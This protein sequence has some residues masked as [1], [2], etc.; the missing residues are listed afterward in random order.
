M[1][2]S[3]KLALERRPC[4]NK[5]GPGELLDA[6]GSYAIDVLDG[7]LP[8]SNSLSHA[9]C[10]NSGKDFGTGA[11]LLCLELE[12]LQP[13]KVVTE[14]DDDDGGDGDDEKIAASNGVVIVRAAREDG[15]REAFSTSLADALGVRCPRVRVLD[16]S[17]DEYLELR[18]AV[19]RILERDGCQKANIVGCELELA[20]ESQVL[21]TE[22]AVHCVGIKDLKG[23]GGLTVD[24][25]Y[26]LGLAVSLDM[27]LANGD[28]MPLKG[29]WDRPGNAETFLF[30]S[31]ET[32]G[33]FTTVFAIDQ[34]CLHSDNVN[35]NEEMHRDYL[36]RLERVLSSEEALMDA[37]G[38]T[39]TFLEKQLDEPLPAGAA[40]LIAAGVKQGVRRASQLSRHRL[41][42]LLSLVKRMAKTERAVW[43]DSL[44]THVRLDFMCDILATF[45]SSAPN[46]VQFTRE[47]GPGGLARILQS[48]TT[49]NAEQ[50]THVEIFLD[51]DR[52]LTNG[53]ITKTD[54]PLAQRVRG[55]ALSVTAL[56]ST[57]KSGLHPYIVTARSP[58]GIVID[59]LVTS[60]RGPQKEI[61]RFFL[62]NDRLHGNTA[63]RC[64][65][66]SFYG[67]DL[68]F[69]TD[70]RLYASDYHKPAAIAHALSRNYAPC[71]TAD[72][73]L[74]FFVD[75]ASVNVHDVGSRLA[76][77]LVQGGR[78]D[79]A[80]RVTV[81]CYWWD[82]FREDTGMSPS[83]APE[84][85][86]TERGYQDFMVNQLLDFGISSL[87]ARRRRVVYGVREG[88]CGRGKGG[89]VGKLERASVG[90][91]ELAAFLFGGGKQKSAS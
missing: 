84:S 16:A 55:G 79:L 24:M 45:H 44:L 41:L 52:T 9:W 6:P 51:F 10:K 5:S 19:S 91:E 29:L 49:S 28:R 61:G 64:E 83:M 60:L 4:P 73:I 85:S 74:V 82:T 88:G 20:R 46:R 13:G 78:G 87:E 31:H 37:L 48:A 67:H 15:A 23:R 80:R 21:V 25:L 68:A 30:R 42:K 66:G 40:H 58:H 18:V 81:R 36:S 72:P 56:H 2:Q 27:L 62:S 69:A 39:T 38:P 34:L 89:R 32:D 26:D 59:Q 33:S 90:Q 75:D 77:L 86:R 22:A 57:T 17:E 14:H 47:E 1:A 71:P 35:D 8:W 53:L 54:L 7:R 50:N 43:D 11:L 63:P 3:G 65:T 12:N 70:A 76:E